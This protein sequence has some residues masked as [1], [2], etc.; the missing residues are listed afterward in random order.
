MPIQDL[1]DAA[2]VGIGQVG[3]QHRLDVR[4]IQR[5]AGNDAVRKAVRPRTVRHR[6]QP[7]RFAYRIVIVPTGI[8]MHRTDYP[9]Y[10]HLCNVV[11]NQIVHPR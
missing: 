7:G 2:Q 9:Q 3:I 11:S 1:P 4:L 10:C 8:Y 5:C 6:L